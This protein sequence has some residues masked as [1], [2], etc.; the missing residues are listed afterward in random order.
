MVSF[1]PHKFHGASW[2]PAQRRRLAKLLAQAT[3]LAMIAL[4]LG[5]TQSAVRKKALE[6]KRRRRKA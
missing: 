4:K 5:R 1:E 6:L 3:P 2:T